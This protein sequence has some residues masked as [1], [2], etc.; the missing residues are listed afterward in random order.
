VAAD[1]ASPVKASES[2]LTAVAVA[3]AKAP[4]NK[5][6][7]WAV[8]SRCQ[9]FAT[10][11]HTHIHTYMHCIA[12]HYIAYIYTHTY[13]FIRIYTYTHVVLTGS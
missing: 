3:F 10:Q 4:E 11:T 6:G 12:L 1:P 13:I 8:S 5:L 7:T 2:L 9:I